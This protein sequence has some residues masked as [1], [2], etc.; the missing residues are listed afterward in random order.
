MERA[1]GVPAELLLGQ[2]HQAPHASAGLHL[3]CERLKWRPKGNKLYEQGGIDLDQTLPGFNPEDAAA[4]IIS[5]DDKTSFPIDTPQA[6]CTPKVETS[7]GPE[8][9]L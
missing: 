7:L 2:M 1:C 8:A 6:V 9:T 3:M 4:V 5:D